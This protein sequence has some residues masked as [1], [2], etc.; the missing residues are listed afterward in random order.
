MG[1]ESDGLVTSKYRNEAIQKRNLSSNT[2]QQKDKELSSSDNEQ[3][4]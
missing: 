4:K 2:L 3:G 1:G